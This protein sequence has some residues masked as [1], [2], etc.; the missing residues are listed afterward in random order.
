MSEAMLGVDSANPS[1]ALGLY[2]RAGFVVHER[3][4]AYRKPLEVSP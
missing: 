1:G 2:E 4:V 3:A